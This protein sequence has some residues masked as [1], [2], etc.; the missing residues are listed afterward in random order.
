[1]C[2]LVLLLVGLGVVVLLLVLL[3]GLVLLLLAW[4][5]VAVIDGNLVN[6]LVVLLL[7]CWL[8]GN[9]FNNHISGLDLFGIIIFFVLLL[10]LLLLLIIIILL[11]LMF[12][13]VFGLGRLLLIRFVGVLRLLMSIVGAVVHSGFG[14]LLLLLSGFTSSLELSAILAVL[15]LALAGGQRRGNQCHKHKNNQQRHKQRSAHVGGEGV[16]VDGGL[17]TNAQLQ[18]LLLKQPPNS[19]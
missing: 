11:L 18:T 3:V 8:A 2:L 14:L 4:L 13:L 16:K 7:A 1:M 17:V 5:V 19:L 6:D 10:L 15:G 12:R 9:L